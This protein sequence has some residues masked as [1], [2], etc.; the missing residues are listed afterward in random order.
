MSC[1]SS[2]VRQLLFADG[3]YAASTIPSFEVGIKS[4]TYFSLDFVTLGAAMSTSFFVDALSPLRFVTGLN[5]ERLVLD[6]CDL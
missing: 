3:G 2:T 4:V 5:A 1:L 6:F